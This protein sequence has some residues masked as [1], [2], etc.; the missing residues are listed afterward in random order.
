M[1][2]EC[3]KRQNKNWKFTLVQFVR[4]KHG[5]KVVHPAMDA[6][7]RSCRVMSKSYDSTHKYY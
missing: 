7:G 6:Y 5:F 1:F 3:I 4:Y 2:K